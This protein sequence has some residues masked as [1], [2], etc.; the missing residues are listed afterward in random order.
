[1]TSQSIPEAMN[2]H[3]QS[4]AVGASQNNLSKNFSE[5]SKNNTQQ[6]TA[7]A[8]MKSNEPL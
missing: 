7:E 4:A 8:I 6:V 2:K 3:I 1:M 5:W